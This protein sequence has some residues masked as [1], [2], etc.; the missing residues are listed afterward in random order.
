MMG[1][2]GIHDTETAQQKINAG[3]T[4]IQFYTAFIYEGPW[5]I[6]K[7]VQTIKSH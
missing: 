3:A 5:L 1:V 7:I 6:K 4:L 2:G